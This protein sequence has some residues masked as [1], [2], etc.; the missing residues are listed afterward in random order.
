MGLG[1]MNIVGFV[2]ARGGSKGIPRKNLRRAAGKSLLAWAIEAG[3]GSRCLSRVIVSTDDEEIAAEARAAGAETPFARPAELAADTTPEW[4]AW[5]HA[6][7]AFNR[8]SPQPLDLFVSIP[9]TAPLRLSADIDA[10]IHTQLAASS[11][12]VVTVTPAR[13]SPYFNM[14]TIDPASASAR[15]VIR[16]EKPLSR[17]QDAPATYDM[18]TVAYVARPAYVLEQSSLFAGDVRAVVIPPERAI[19]I[20]SELDFEVAEL[21]LRRRLAAAGPKG[22]AA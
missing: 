16:P 9:P 17:R 13:R 14:V 19:D 10:C 15:L 7:I 2:F 22:R 6:I 5:R 20:D 12:A 21:L 11:D 18:T 3:K 8:I 1:G 4:L